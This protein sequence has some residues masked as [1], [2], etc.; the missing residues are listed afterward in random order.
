VNARLLVGLALVCLLPCGLARSVR[1]EENGPSDNRLSIY[2]MVGGAAG[3]SDL[4]Y[5]VRKGNAFGGGFGVMFGLVFP[6]IAVP[7]GDLAL[8]MYGGGDVMGGSEHTSEDSRAGVWMNVRGEGGFQANFP[9]RWQNLRVSVRA[10][11]VYLGDDVA[12]GVFGKGVKVRI[13]RQQ[14]AVEL[15]HA[16][17]DAQVES[18]T[19]R[20]RESFLKCFGL[21]V[22]RVN[23]PNRL[24]D[25]V[26]VRLFY[27]VDI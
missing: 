3:R 12:G 20:W 10:G 22:E 7:G 2:G 25:G 13:D 1:A 24:S 14:F 19:L 26:V 5:G 9:I 8:G 6:F 16:W 23:V 27:A 17:N 18:L 11:G 4:N 21:G 15:G